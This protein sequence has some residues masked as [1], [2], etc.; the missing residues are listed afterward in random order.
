MKIEVTD[1]VKRDGH[2]AALEYRIFESILKWR[3]SH[4]GNVE[5]EFTDRV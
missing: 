3:K 5:Y 4:Y 1:F 2:R